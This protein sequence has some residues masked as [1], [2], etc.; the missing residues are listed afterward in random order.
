VNMLLL[1]ANEPSHTWPML[2]ELGEQL[3]EFISQA[4][5]KNA[6]ILQ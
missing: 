6:A 3:R 5:A 1:D 4:F 2:R